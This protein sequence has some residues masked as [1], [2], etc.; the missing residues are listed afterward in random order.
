[1]FSSAKS[2]NKIQ[3]LQKRALRY[4][5]SDYESPYDTFLVKSSK[6]TMKTSRLRSLCVE[7]YKSIN[8]V[9]P[10]F[11]KKIFRLRGPGRKLGYCGNHGNHGDSSWATELQILAIKIKKEKQKSKFDK[12]WEKKNCKLKIFRDFRVFVLRPIPKNENS[13]IFEI[14]Q[15]RHNTVIWECRFRNSWNAVQI[16]SN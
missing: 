11:M 1:M 10:S 5:Y 15:K 7:I 16:T 3:S 2:F 8:S 9:N 14:L 13:E 6:V 12:F 4:L